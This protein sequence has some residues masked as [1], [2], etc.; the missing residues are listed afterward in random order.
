MSWF[1]PLPRFGLWVLFVATLAVALVVAWYANRYRQM[2]HA[3]EVLKQHGVHLSP[4]QEPHPWY[5]RLPFLDPPSR[6]GALYFNSRSNVAAV[7]PEL[8]S[9]GTVRRVSLYEL[10]AR[11]IE[12]LTQIDS[13]REVEA[14]WGLETNELRPLLAL[15]LEEFC[16]SG[17]DVDIPRDQLELLLSL[18]TLQRIGMASASFGAPDDL[19]AKRPDVSYFPTDFPP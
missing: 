18:P 19:R 14:E 15:P 5:D 9:L 13:I 17:A 16:V 10:S 6:I 11:D 4:F 8:Q 1:L 7:V 2:Q 3:G 12:L